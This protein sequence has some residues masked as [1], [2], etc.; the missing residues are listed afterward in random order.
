M[1]RP[2]KLCSQSCRRK[3]NAKGF[4]LRYRND[5]EF[6]LV[7]LIRTLTHKSLRAAHEP[8]GRALSWLGCSI[9]EL[10]SYVE[11]RFLPGMTWDNWGIGEGKWNLTHVRSLST[12][13]LTD[14]R[15]LGKALH[16]ANLQ[17][18]WW[19]DRLPHKRVD[20]LSM[21][22]CKRLVGDL[23]KSSYC[24]AS[25]Q[26]LAAKLG[27]SPRTLRRRLLALKNRGELVRYTAAECRAGTWTKR[28]LMKLNAGN[29]FGL[30]RQ[31]VLSFKRGCEVQ[32]PDNTDKKPDLTSAEN[33]IPPIQEVEGFGQ[34]RHE[35]A[36][37]TGAMLL[38]DVQ[39][40]LEYIRQQQ[41]SYTPDQE[42]EALR[43]KYLQAVVARNR[44][45]RGE[46]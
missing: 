14:H 23:S 28:R 43:L 6:R 11:S 5:V 46:I 44:R 32:L 40:S 21:D 20:E 34:P 1:G 38:S 37:R 15:Q 9:T 36:T 3:H 45:A 42:H 12:F 29:G 18:R 30:H 31:E 39:K 19:K 8:S 2:R 25:D 7:H 10:M 24:N 16:H 27:V 26:F 41:T 35:G 17:P 22:R 4:R 33:G 13:N